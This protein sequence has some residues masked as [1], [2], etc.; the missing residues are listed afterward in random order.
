MHHNHVHVLTAV[1]FDINYMYHC[2]L[3]EV[4]VQVPY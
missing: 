4:Q 2:I 3:I 1:S